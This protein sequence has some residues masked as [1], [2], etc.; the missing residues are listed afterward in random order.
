[1]KWA[2][3][4]GFNYYETSAATKTGV[5]EMVNS[6]LSTIIER[7]MIKPKWIGNEN[8]PK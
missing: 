8:K 3:E 5:K 2:A 6:L 7:K 4:H 1:M